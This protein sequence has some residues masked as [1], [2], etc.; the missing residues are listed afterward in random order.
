[1]VETRFV[2]PLPVDAEDDEEDKDDAVFIS[3]WRSE[4]GGVTPD[5]PDDEEVDNEDEDDDDVAKKVRACDAQADGEKEETA[6]DA[7]D[8]GDDEEAAD[9][10]EEEGTREGVSAVKGAGRCCCPRG[11]GEGGEGDGRELLREEA[12]VC[13]RA[14]AAA[15]EDDDEVGIRIARD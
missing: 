1:M 5:T 4:V 3:N 9:G 2:P 10:G 14:E 11:R 7:D 12:S 13:V 15:A 8:A 6:G